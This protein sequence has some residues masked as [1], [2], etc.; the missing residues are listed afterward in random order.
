ML[1]TALANALPETVASWNALEAA[2]L[3]RGVT[4]RLNDFGGVRTQ[5]DTTLIEQY[6]QTD[7]NRALANGSIAADTTLNQFRPI[8]P[9]GHS[10]HNYGA[11]FD[12]SPESRPAD[13]SYDAAV[14]L[15]GSLAPSCG[16][17]WPLPASDPA[18]FELNI[19]LAAAAA[20]WSNWVASGEQSD[21]LTPTQQVEVAVQDPM[22]WALLASVTYTAFVVYRALVP[23]WRRYAAQ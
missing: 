22:F 8:A 20:K 9:W 23:K 18:H 11:A 19:S 13:M 21:T 12:I 2:A 1:P 17:K 16:L 14:K 10:F 5:A 15:L 3:S 7:Y 4:F 6:R